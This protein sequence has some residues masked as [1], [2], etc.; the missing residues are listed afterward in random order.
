MSIKEFMSRYKKPKDERLVA[1][2]NK[3]YRKGFIALSFGFLV[4]FYYEA[5]RRQVVMVHGLSDH[6]NFSAS[7]VLLYAWFLVVMFACI[8]VSSRR[9]F[10]DDSR[11]GEADR[12]PSAYYSSITGFTAIALGLLTALFRTFAEIE[13][14]G[15][16][17][18]LW[19]GNLVV[20]FVYF[21]MI[22]PFLYFLFYLNF[23]LAKRGRQK[24]AK[25]FED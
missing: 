4:Y 20:G 24:I 11:F 14:F 18:V 9:G 3:I 1:E 10:M 16:G 25:S 7:E 12:F 6:I 23:R 2:V 22:F 17:E 5:M 19:L 13:L 8:L 15:V 21:L